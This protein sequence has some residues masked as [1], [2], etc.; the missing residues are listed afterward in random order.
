MG[1]DPSLFFDEDG[2]AWYTG[3]RIPNGG[4]TYP[5]DCEIWL[6]QLDLD[7]IQL[8]GKI[9]V[10]WGGAVDGCLHVEAPHLFKYETSHINPILTHRH[11]GF[12]YRSA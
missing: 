12:E 1:I 9:N 10:L 4:E 5:G 11:L 6:Q 7:T 2:T 3:N 8:T